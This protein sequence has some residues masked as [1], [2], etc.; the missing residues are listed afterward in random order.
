MK[1]VVIHSSVS[2]QFMMKMKV[3][4]WRWLSQGYK[5]QLHLLSCYFPIVVAEISLQFLTY[6]WLKLTRWTALSL[7]VF[8]FGCAGTHTTIPLKRYWGVFFCK[9]HSCKL[10]A[11][12]NDSAPLHPTFAP[13]NCGNLLGME[14]C[15]VDVHHCI[16]LLPLPT[17]E[18][19]WEWNTAM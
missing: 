13:Y 9:S 10:E 7:V 11:P 8:F 5:L 6:L 17:V 1:S 19:F 12:S 18:I 16:L 3:M 15:N 14:D 4:V 2:Q